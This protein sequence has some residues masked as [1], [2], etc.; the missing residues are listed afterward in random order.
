MFIQGATFIPDS[1]ANS[2]NENG[3]RLS[4]EPS[5]SNFKKNSR[6]LEQFFL[7]LCQNN[8]GNKILMNI[9]SYQWSLLY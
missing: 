1:R 6:S 8:F 2:Q 5:A 3:P 7:K 4:F 9:S